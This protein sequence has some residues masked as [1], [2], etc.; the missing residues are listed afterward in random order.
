MAESMKRF[1]RVEHFIA[2][3]ENTKTD[4]IELL[5]MNGEDITVVY[6]GVDPRY[7]P[8]D[9]HGVRERVT[10]GKPYL[11]FLGT[12]EPRKNLVNLLKAFAGVDE[13]VML[14][15][16]GLRGWG[17]GEV[18]EAIRDL[19]LAERVRFAGFTPEEDL[20]A[21][22]SGADLFVYPS[23]YEGFG[24]PPVEAMACGAPVASS[25]GGSLPE[26]LGD[27]AVYFEP[28]DVESMRQAI[29]TLLS[30]GELRRRCIDRG[31][32]RAKTYTWRNCATGVCD[33]YRKYA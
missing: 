27:A 20:P 28:G 23:W 16:S 22:Y 4:M 14:V 19:A 12:V 25:T 32:E 3:S 29:Q 17:Y 21:L 33:V 8:V 13:D 26:V 10:G 18:S 24:L 6:P 15:L 7:R 2:D 1:G 9:P 31:V 11:L 5:G 30:D